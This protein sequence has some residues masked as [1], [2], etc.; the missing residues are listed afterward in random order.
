[1]GTAYGARGLVGGNPTGFLTYTGAAVVLGLES[2]LRPLW[3]GW[4]TFDDNRISR[5]LGID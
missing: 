5:I 3:R 1:M 2:Y 4:G